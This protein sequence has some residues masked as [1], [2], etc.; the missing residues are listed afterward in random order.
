MATFCPTWT[1]E[2]RA[3]RAEWLH[4]C[5]LDAIKTTFDGFHTDDIHV[6]LPHIK[7][8]MRLVVAGDAPVIGDDDVA[9]IRTLAP[10]IDVR[11]VE[12]AGHMIPWDNLDGFINAVQDFEA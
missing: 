6:D 7:L 9:E 12:R 4:T 10:H 11:T 8:P 2:Q 5:Q 1:L 3:L